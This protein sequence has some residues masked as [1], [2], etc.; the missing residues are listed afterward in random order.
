MNNPEMIGTHKAG[1]VLALGILGI[2]WFAAHGGSGVKGWVSEQVWR[3]SSVETLPLKGVQEGPLMRTGI[4][5]SG[6][7]D[8]ESKGGRGQVMWSEPWLW[9]A[10]SELKPAYS[11]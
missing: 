6:V 3:W 8:W 2:H 7:R 11:V 1:C 4:G 5:G 9:P 10:Q